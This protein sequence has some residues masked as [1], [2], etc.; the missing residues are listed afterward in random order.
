MPTNRAT[1][2]AGNV[3]FVDGNGVLTSY[4]RNLLVQLL[5]STFTGT[6]ATGWA[7][8]SG[9]GSRASINGSF[10]EVASA[11]YTQAQVQAISNQVS[12][13]SAALA[14]LIIDLEAVGAIA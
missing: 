12:A 14:Q 7:T 9:T 8:P 2:P 10:T 5:N 4:G 3:A 13:L 11:G 1:I 6:P